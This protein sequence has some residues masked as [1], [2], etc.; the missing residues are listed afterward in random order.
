MKCKRG[1]QMYIWVILATFLAILASYS[2]SVR[3]DMRELSV[4][5]VAEAVLGRL[6]VQ[7]EAALNYV[8]YHKYPYSENRDH[9]DYSPGVINDG[10]LLA[11]MPYG[12]N[13]DGQYVSKIFCMNQNMTVAYGGEGGANPC[14][15][16]DNRKMVVTYGPIPTRWMSLSSAMERPNTDFLN[17]LWNMVSSGEEFGYMIPALASDVHASSENPSA[18]K[19]QLATRAGNEKIFVPKAVVEDLDFKSICDL[20]E[21]FICLVYMSG[22]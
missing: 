9:V 3:P 16:A 17:A 8:K 6:V 22:I 15:V 11:E 5:R 21:N 18:S 1:E 2:L 13:M 14:D 20:D 4:A 12:Y 10:D 7:H 19:V